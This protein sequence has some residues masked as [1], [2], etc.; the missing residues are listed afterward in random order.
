MVSISCQWLGSPNPCSV[1]VYGRGWPQLLGMQCHTVV[2]QM[3]VI[4]EV[5]QPL[6]DGYFCIRKLS[7]LNKAEIALA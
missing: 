3:L 2:I 7:K 4:S 1:D 5:E 6:M